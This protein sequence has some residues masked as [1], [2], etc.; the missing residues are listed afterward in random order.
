[1]V[2]IRMPKTIN[3][4][5]NWRSI[6]RLCLLFQILTGL[7]LSIH[8]ETEFIVLINYMWQS[9]FRFNLRFLHINTASL[10]ELRLFLHIFKS[11]KVVSFGKLHVIGSRIAIFILI[12]A[13]CFMGYVLPYRQIS[14][15]AA[16]VIINLLSIL[17][18]SQYII[19]TIW[20]RFVVCKNT[21]MWFYTLHF[22]L[23]FLVLVLVLVH[24]IILH[25]CGSNRFTINLEKLSFFPTW[26]VKDLISWIL[27]V[28]VLL[29]LYLELPNVLGDVENFIAGNSFVTPAH[30]LPEWYYLPEY[31]ILWACS[32]KVVGVIIIFLSVLSPGFMVVLS[33]FNLRSNINTSWAI[34]GGYCIIF[35]LLITCGR[36]PVIY[37]YLE[38]SQTLTPAYFI[39]CVL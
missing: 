10:F 23:P 25:T 9:E 15:W 35:M 13:I 2:Y 16:I 11:I 7:L 17:P 39:S 32:S 37:P 31:R 19:V 38:M 20:G 6:I 26:G 24:L 34:I 14:F 36:S 1:M 4:L 29:K 30:I 33:K 18:Y 12:Q 8:F 22:L 3:Y 5:Y 21:A 28:I 27:L